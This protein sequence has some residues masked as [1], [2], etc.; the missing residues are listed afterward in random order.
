[1]L[2]SVEELTESRAPEHLRLP[3]F[4]QPLVTALQLAIVAVLND[5]GVYPRSVV[6]HSSGEIAVAAAA[7]YITA[8]EAI[9]VAY[10]RGKAAADLQHEIVEE[11]G[12]LAVGLGSIEV[13]T[14]LE[15]APGLVQIACENSQHSVTLSG[16][17]IHLEAIKERLQADG[18]FARLL[19]VNLA[20][21]SS[22]MSGIGSYYK[23]LL[24]DHCKGPTSRHSNV[25]MF[26]SV[27]GQLFDGKCDADYWHS[28]MVSPV[29]FKSATE[30]LIKGGSAHLLLEVGP[31]KA[32]AGPIAQIKKSFGARAAATEYHAAL[33][34]G[35]DPVRAIFE[36]A[37]Q[38][39]LSGASIDMSKVN[40]DRTPSTKQPMEVVDLPNYA[41][42]HSIKY[43][44]ESDASKDWRFRR[45]LRHDLLGSKIMGT[46]WHAPSWKNIM[47]VNEVSWLK[48]HRVL[49]FH[50]S[51]TNPG[52]I[53]YRSLETSYFLPQGI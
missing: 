36:V 53:R 15:T 51:L 47:S 52:L 32:L 14:Y 17:L 16:L 3:E 34:R 21:H 48:D 5:W 50:L 20:Y 33:V 26:S 18:H 12:M 45:F 25:A 39:F 28:N 2:T 23:T 35:S 27:T 40:E 41:W 49:S 29:L 10:F 8:G 9:K 4:S 1:M 11:L 43:W 13:R 30:E 24:L 7:G 6:G 19:Q 38:I 42:D 44:H 46:S 22:F 37:G 31:S